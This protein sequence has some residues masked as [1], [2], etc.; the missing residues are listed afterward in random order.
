MGRSL[1]K[2]Y[3]DHEILSDIGSLDGIEVR[4]LIKGRAKL[5]INSADYPVDYAALVEAATGAAAM[6]YLEKGERIELIKPSGKSKESNM[7]LLSAEA[8]VSRRIGDE[9][10]VNVSVLGTG[11]KT[12]D[13]KTLTYKV[14]KR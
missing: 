2:R 14:T 1:G 4:G 10:S 5:A 8:S 9:I 12:V 13:F 3:T 7:P 6:T 11:G